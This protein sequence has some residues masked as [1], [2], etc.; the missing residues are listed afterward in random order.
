MTPE[1]LKKEQE[2]M[3]EITRKAGDNS[4]DIFPHRHKRRMEESNGDLNGG[5][6]QYQALLAQLPGEKSSKSL[7][8][9][10]IKRPTSQ[11]SVQSKLSRDRT[12]GN[13]SRVFV[14]LDM[15]MT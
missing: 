4:V 2:A 13:E 15:D 1:E 12:N 10:S 9:A 7:R 6:S 3:D 5:G 11:A 14:K 8:V